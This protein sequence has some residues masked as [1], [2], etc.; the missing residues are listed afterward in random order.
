MKRVSF[1]RLN[2]AKR[3]EKQAEMNVGSIDT[4]NEDRDKHLRSGDFFDADNK[5]DIKFKSKSIKGD[6]NNGFKI[7]GDLSIGGV[8]HETTFSASGI[9]FMKDPWGNEKIAAS[10]TTSINRTDYGLIW[11]K[12]LEAGGMLVGEIVTI[13]IEVQLSKAS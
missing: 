3:P 10:A 9:A 1:R 11:N 5:P 8:T 2:L 6:I 7:T 13:E 12:T 4:G